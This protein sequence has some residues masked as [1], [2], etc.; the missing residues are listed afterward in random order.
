VDSIEDIN[1][2]IRELERKKKELLE[3][4]AKKKEA[5]IF[6]H[7]QRVHCKTGKYDHE[8]VTGLRKFATR[9]WDG[10]DDNSVHITEW[11]LLKE[12]LLSLKYEMEGDWEKFD[13]EADEILNA[14]DYVF[15]LEKKFIICK[16]KQG[17]SLWDVR[18]PNSSSSHN[19]LEIPF[20]EAWRI[21]EALERLETYEVSEEVKKIVEKQLEKRQ[22]LDEVAEVIDSDFPQ[23]ELNGYILKGFQKAA[24]E[25]A[26][27]AEGR[28]ILGHEMG[29]GKTPIALSYCEYL[30]QENEEKIPNSSSSSTSS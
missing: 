16:A 1:T 5:K 27:L 6:S 11:P 23:P 21:P 28:V 10:G 26:I 17:K 3:E 13:K 4:Q 30:R 9:R 25:F 22:K 19:K 2:Q 18:I 7:N 15:S 12:L 24:L 8:L 20:L 14:P 29:L